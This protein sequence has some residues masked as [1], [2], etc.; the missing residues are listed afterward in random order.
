MPNPL[1]PSAVTLLD[2]AVATAARRT[3]VPFWPSFVRAKE[4]DASTPP[5]ARLIQGGRGGEVRLKLYLCITMM[6]TAKPHDIRRPPTPQL[7]SRMLALPPD[8]GPR[9]VNSNLK[10][11]AANKFIELK[12][13]RGNTPMIQMLSLD[14]P[15]IPPSLNM[16]AVP[17]QRASA[18]ARY[19]GVP[20][21]FW[22]RGWIVE[23]GA[24]AIALMLIL[25]ESQGG[26]DR[27]RYVPRERREAY[28]VSHN[29]W[30]QGR[31]DLER[32]GLL[33]VGRT[34]QGGDFDYTRMRNTYWI[35]EKR[36]HTPPGA[37]SHHSADPTIPAQ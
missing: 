26:Y 4:G 29:T 36:L 30:T 28:G 35:N 12:P 13:R 18:Q 37:V 1:F 15:P 7:W 2:K 23:L 21:E 16:P 10:W 27:P 6:A 25:L 11:L 14:A 17:Y 8:T 32:H 20:T 9:R 24:T 3:Q 34:P 19:I 33:T 22:S 31:K 5:L